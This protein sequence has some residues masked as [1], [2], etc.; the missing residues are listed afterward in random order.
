MPSGVVLGLVRNLTLVVYESAAVMKETKGTWVAIVTLRSCKKLQCGVVTEVWHQVLSHYLHR[1]LMVSNGPLLYFFTNL[2]Y[3]DHIFVSRQPTS[4]YSFFTPARKTYF[5]CDLR[6][7]L[8][9]KQ[10]ME[11]SILLVAIRHFKIHPLLSLVC[12]IHEMHFAVV[13][14]NRFDYLVFLP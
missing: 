1:L 14:T 13:Y 7:F 8:E 10:T 11:V 2:Y 3:C 9:L 12:Q 5:I 4:L 6:L